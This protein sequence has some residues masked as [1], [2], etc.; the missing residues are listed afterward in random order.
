MTRILA[1]LLSAS[2]LAACAASPTQG[3]SALPRDVTLHPG[4]RTSLSQDTVLRYLGTENDSR[5]PPDV[6][7][8]WA[9]DALVRLRLERPAGVQDV[10]LHT[11]DAAPGAAG[12]WRIQLL[13][14]DRGPSPAATLRIDAVADAH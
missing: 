7:C 5:C 2:L 9:G 13:R 8:V 10:E 4:E 12:Q 11:A 1:V 6:Q 14:L 3:A